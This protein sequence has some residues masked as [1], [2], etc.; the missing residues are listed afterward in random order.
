MTTLAPSVCPHDCTSVCALDVEVKDA[1]TIG[2]VR[3]STRNAYTAGVICEKVARYA[4]RVHHPGRLTQPLLRD[5]PKG[6]G[7]FKPIAWN[8]ALDR[9]AAAFTDAAA[10]HGSEAVWPY[11]YAGT[12]GL[13][14]RDGIQRL[15]HVMKYSRWHSTICVALSDSGWIAGVGSKRGV[16][17]LEAAE[18]SDLIVIWGGNPVN[19]QVNVMTHAMAARKRGA[20]LVVVDPYRTGTAEKAD[21]HLALKP[22]TDG[23][24]ACAVM[25][26]LFA[27]GLADREYLQRYSDAPA[28]LEAHL[29]TRTPQW[30][31]AI[32]GLPAQVI[33]DFARLYGGTKKSYIRAHHG[34]SRSRNGAANM[35]A[36]TCLPTVTGAWRHRGGGALYGNA[37]LYPVD[38]TLIEG[39]DALDTS[40]RE[41]DQSRLGPILT[42]D[43]GA[44]KGGPPVT[45]MLVQNTNPAMVCPDLNLVHRGLAREDLFLCVHEQF[46]TETAAFADV[47]L[48]ATTFLE[49]DDFYTAAGHSVFQASLK[50]IEAPGAA[51]EN[52]H[53]ICELARRLG[54][55]HRGF[56]LSAREIMDETLRASGMWDVATNVARG[57][58]DMALPFEKMH[59]HDGFDTADGK[60]HFRGD[61]QRFGGR[62]QEMPVLPDHFDVIDNATPA[63]PYRL[64]AAP[65][66]TFLNSTFTETPSSLKREVRPTVLIH[67]DECAALGVGDGDRVRLG[68]ARGCV[69]VHV[70]PAPGQQRDVV[71][72]EGIWPNKHF[73]NGLGI[74]ALTSADPGWPNGG[75]AFHDTAVWV[76]RAD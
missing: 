4:E 3:G 76:K 29:A 53:V 46:M 22:G 10:R 41:L 67:P 17:M 60:F 58:Q 27:E 42:G 19:T 56:T 21:L 71:V 31:S 54:A 65:A 43:A 26:V 36:V 23:A 1:R 64:V 66:R 49:H 74:N 39:L 45:A 9:V 35:H 50:L 28:A 13:V 62:W 6:S 63:T 48:P 69:I 40:I 18:H 59:F 47:V 15:R 11:F 12:M 51:R 25:H 52:H 7:R 57:G 24:L 68:N 5:G 2:R 33:I 73:E 34:F 30:A 14:Q 37:A 38:K 75:A 16:S 20:T 32:T 61:W 55:E 72:V 70:R 8:E 44:L